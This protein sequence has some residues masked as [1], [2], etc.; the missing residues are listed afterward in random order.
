[1]KAIRIGICALIAFAVAALG[2]VEWWGVG[3]VEIGA[4]GLFLLWGIFALLQ[5]HTDITWNWVYLPMLGIAT[6]V[7]T[8][9]L[10]GVSA[11]PYATNMELLKGVTYLVL[12]FLATESFR[13]TEDRVALTWFLVALSFIFSVFGIVQQLTFDGKLYWLVPVPDGAEPFGSFV[14]RDH[15]AGFVELTAPLGLAMLFNGAYRRDKTVLLTLFTA[16]PIVAML[17]SGSRGGNASFAVASLVAVALSRPRL[18]GRKQMRGVLTL[19]VLA[20]VLATWLG[21][22]ATIERFERM[23]PTALTNSQRLAMDRETW[24]IFLDHPWMGTGLG[25][26]ETVY[27]K[28]A[29][30]YDGRVVDHVH[31]DYLEF[32]AETGGIGGALGVEF[33]AVLLWAGIQNWRSAADARDRA[34]RVGALAACAALLL[35]SSVDFNLHIPSNALL[36]LL[37]ATLVC[38]KTPISEIEPNQKTYQEGMT[39]GV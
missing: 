16:M 36:F 22:N 37:L 27:P 33:L 11:Y 6:L 34:F 14:N 13:T 8:Q 30:F 21:A 31:N 26:L 10:F 38:A 1:M 4:A 5:R 23:S 28:Y 17:L 39:A 20:G 9:K 3:I 2:G 15:F 12:C 19:V 29:S 35:H 24:R 18:V 7:G 32:L 25:T